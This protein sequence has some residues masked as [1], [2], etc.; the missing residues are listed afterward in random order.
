MPIATTVIRCCVLCAMWCCRRPV[1]PII[2]IRQQAGSYRVRPAAN[3]QNAAIPVG[4]SLLTLA[5]T[6][7]VSTAN[8]GNPALFVGD[9]GG[10][11]GMGRTRTNAVCHSAWMS[12][13]HRIRRNAAQTKL[14]STG[15]A[16]GLMAVASA[17]PDQQ[18]ARPES[19]QPRQ[20]PACAVPCILRTAT[21]RPMSCLIPFARSS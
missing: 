10:Y 18:F 9:V 15:I 14:A 1:H 16:L 13:T 19:P 3:P 12:L 8:S 5:P 4:V 11:E 7:R 2:S 6:G 17:T 20:N 21:D